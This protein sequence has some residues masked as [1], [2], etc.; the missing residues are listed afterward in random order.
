MWFRINFCVTCIRS[1]TLSHLF[2]IL[3]LFVPLWVFLYW[4]GLIGDTWIP[5]TLLLSVSESK[6]SFL[7]C[8][9]QRDGHHLPLL[10][11]W[12]DLWPYNLDVLKCPWPRSRWMKVIAKWPWHWKLINEQ[13]SCEW[14]LDNEKL[15]RVLYDV[16]YSRLWEQTWRKCCLV[17]L[18]S[19]RNSFVYMIN[20]VV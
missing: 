8:Y 5:G 19:V 20:A 1:L 14:N 6:S 3:C 18:Q 13:W 7:L 11:A 17:N 2:F 10:L 12:T 4:P 16:I 15:R 9:F